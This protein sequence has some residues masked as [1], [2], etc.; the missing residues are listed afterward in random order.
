MTD[1]PS[2]RIYVNKIEN[3]ITL[4]TQ[5]GY[6]LELITTESMNLLGSTKNKITKDKNGENVTHLENAEVVLIYCNIVD[7]DYQHDSRALYT[8]I[9]NKKFGQLLDIST[10]NLMFLRTFKSEFSFIEV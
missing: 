6:Y 3:I 1:N 7:N 4:K 9:P 2:I 8:F 10:K 5:T